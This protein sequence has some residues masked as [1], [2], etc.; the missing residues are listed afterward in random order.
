MLD[1]PLSMLERDVENGFWWQDW[2]D[3]PQTPVERAEVLR[4]ELNRAP[5]LIPLLAHR[6]LP[7]SPRGAGNPV[8]SMHGVDTIYYG[9]DL[10][11][12][13]RR[14]FDP[15]SNKIAYS[16]SF[17]QSLHEVTTLLPRESEAILAD[18]RPRK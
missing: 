2:G 6:F 5:R 8:L 14:E 12:Y 16:Q 11:D 4:G 18:F 7:E 10:T 3:R 17:D 9:S 1:W 15:A 13:F